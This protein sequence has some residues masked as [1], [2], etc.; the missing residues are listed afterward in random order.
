MTVKMRLHASALLVLGLFAASACTL[1][2]PCDP[3]YTFMNAA[4]FPD[5]VASGGSP[6][7]GGQGGATSGGS[8]STAGAPGTDEP[9]FTEPCTSD[10]DCTGG[11]TCDEAV[12]KTCLPFCGPGDSFEDNCPEGTV[13][14]DFGIIVC[15]PEM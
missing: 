12:T 1:D 4:C 14:Q 7:S 9:N 11:G 6:G 10:E 3:G 5:E 15:A 2:E 8:P 13:C